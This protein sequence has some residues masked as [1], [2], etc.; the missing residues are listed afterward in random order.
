MYDR[1]ENGD[2]EHGSQVEFTSCFGRAIKI[3]IMSEHQ[4]CLRAVT[5]AGAV[6]SGECKQSPDCSLRSHLKHRAEVF[7]SGITAL[8]GH[9]V[10]I[11][12]IADDE[13]A[14]GIRAVSSSE[15]CQ[16]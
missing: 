1:C 6:R 16:G 10:K 2:A 14:I 9:A 11:S 7:P 15:T 8:A 5:K 3:S 4:G 12:I 13:A